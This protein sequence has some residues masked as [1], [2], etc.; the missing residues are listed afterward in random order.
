MAQVTTYLLVSGLKESDNL[1]G[2]QALKESEFEV[3]NKFEQRDN[4]YGATRFSF[5]CP[6]EE[7]ESTEETAIEVSKEFPNSTV[8]LCAVEQRFGQIEHMQTTVFKHGTCVGEIEHGSLYN[9]G[10]PQ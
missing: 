5:Q 3:D 10:R 8:T 7:K 1:V 2:Q 4:T 9:V 6:I